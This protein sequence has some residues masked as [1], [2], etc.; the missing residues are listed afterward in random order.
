VCS[1]PIFSPSTRRTT[2]KKRKAARGITSRSRCAILAP[3]KVNRERLHSL[4]EKKRRGKKDVRRKGK[5]KVSTRPRPRRH[6]EF[7]LLDYPLSG[8]D[9]KRRKKKKGEGMRKSTLVLPGT[10]SSRVGK[11]KE[12][13]KRREG[14]ERTA[15]HRI[16]LLPLNS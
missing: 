14:Q 11:K 9:P 16:R 3:D 4:G 6:P 15:S 10:T 13:K 2:G 1:A 5:E 12:K 7:L 8:L